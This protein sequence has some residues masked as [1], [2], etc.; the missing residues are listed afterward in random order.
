MKKV[1]GIQDIGRIEVIAPNLKRRLSGVTTTVL[2]L[3]PVQAKSI[4]IVTTGP[5]LPEDIPHIPL[6]KL[7]LLSRGRWRVWHAR[8]NT[9]MALGLVL[10]YIFRRKL[11]LLFT[12]AA[13]RE[14]SSYTKA[15]ISR[16]D[17]VIAT[18]PQAASYLERSA[19][20]IMHGVDTEEFQPVRD[21]DALREMLGLPR[22]TLIGCF[23]RIRHQ[24]GTDVLIEA[25][26]EVLPRHPDAA[27]VFTGRVTADNQSYV[28]DLKAG[29]TA[30]GLAEAVMFRGEVSW[31]DL[32]RHYQ[33]MDL[34][35]AP[36]RWEGF[37][38]TPIEAM[39]C[40]V[41]A[42]ATRVGAFETQIVEGETGRLV[43][44]GDAKGLAAAIDAMLTDPG[45][46]ERMGKAARAHVLRHFSIKREADAIISVYRDL[47]A[48]PPP[49][50]LSTRIRLAV[51]R[52]G[53]ADR[54]AEYSALRT[55]LLEEL[56]GKRI[57]I[58][59]NARALAASEQ[60]EMID[61]CDLVIR[62]NR[63][64][65]PSAESHGAR[66]DWLALATSLNRRQACEIHPR[67]VLW[68]SHKR[69]RLPLWALEGDGF[70]LH[71]IAEFS[72]LRD[73][74]GAPP[75]TGLMVIALVAQSEAAAIELFGFDFFA[76]LSL[77][78]RRTALEVPHDFGGEAAYVEDL[79][80]RDP[81]VTMHP[82]K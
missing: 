64:P 27:I 10:R 15:L 48:L 34:F 45:E 80:S 63:A 25:A 30:A 70:Y 31:A 13:Q 29:L 41:P 51:N 79:I 20:V 16:M 75:T 2:R 42:V 46:L 65:R 82:M 6:W 35:V 66:T 7:F 56:R 57:A 76:S 71:S 18:S 43:D 14:H 81:R 72:A 3:V 55:E 38:L 67:R 77:T 11:R 60:G 69:K 37:G 73:Q 78:G 53:K 8:R 5:G 59:G 21:K 9:E 28:E 61:D 12:S 26:L 54:L 39:A 49:L 68:M 22:G 52:R 24:K 32:V 40:E 17:A 50:T 62:I 47:L 1:I 36:A 74:V 4:G 58:V 33:A 44:P 23:G 19:K